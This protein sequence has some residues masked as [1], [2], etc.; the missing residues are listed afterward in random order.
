MRSAVTES[1]T[2]T[3]LL[4]EQLGMLLQQGDFLA[5]RGDLGSGKTRFASGVARGLG[6]PPATPITSPTFTL[7]NIYQGRLPLYHF[8]LYRL[9]GDDDVINLG[10][11]EYFSGNGVSLVEWAERLVQELPAQRLEITFSYL[12]EERRKI[13]LLP[14]GKR[15]VTLLEHLP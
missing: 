8:D 12:S 9:S 7:M 14:V 13:D 6:I 10:F 5:L 15:F 11:D 1:P 3:E 4:G 2:A